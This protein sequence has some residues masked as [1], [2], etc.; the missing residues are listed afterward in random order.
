MA[1]DCSQ[2]AVDGGNI[3]GAL[4]P[5]FLHQIELTRVAN[6]VPAGHVFCEQGD[7]VHAVHCILR[8]AVKLVKSGE[9]GDN[10]VIRLLGPHGIFGL[11]PVLAGDDYAVR[12]VAVEESVVCTIP[13]E[14][15]RTLLRESTR[16]AAAVMA[17]L[18]RE[19][20]ISEE[21]LMVLTQCSVRRRVAELLLLLNGH[22]LAGNEWNPLP[23]VKLKRREIAQMVSTSPET[24]SRTLADMARRKLIR[25]DRKEITI[26]DPA[27]LQQLDRDEARS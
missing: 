18:A 24:L 25:F 26:L 9:R 16:F 20:R 23:R 17:Y 2:C 12:A 11:R 22:A 1:P 15:I 8:G 13:K 4:E 14:T 21:F 6:R 10:Q 19:I 3:F 7:P 27:G 5:H